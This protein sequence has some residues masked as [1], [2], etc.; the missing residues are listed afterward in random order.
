LNLVSESE[1]R[2]M[3]ALEYTK[4]LSANPP[5]TGTAQSEMVQRVGSRMAAAVAEYLRTKNQTELAQGYQWEFNLINN[6]Q[7]NAWCMPG[8]KVAIYTGILPYTADESGLAVVM[9]HEIAHAIARHANERVSQQLVAEYGAQTLS[10]V[11][12]SNPSTASKVFNAAVGVGGQLGL[13]KFSR[14]QESEADQMGLIFM[15]L[16]GYDPNTALTFWQRMSNN[17]GQKPPEILSSHP[18]DDTR[19]QDIRKWIPEAMKYYKAP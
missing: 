5:V 19:I 9:G 7:A 15:A 12:S 1:M 3:A 18:S 6:N 2:Q 4:V 10:A 11:M 16:A 14:A 17:A 8:G 13:L